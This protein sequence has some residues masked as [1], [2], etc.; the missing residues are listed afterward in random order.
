MNVDVK[1]RYFVFMLDRDNIDYFL[2]HHEMQLA[3][4]YI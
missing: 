2:K 1:D 3:L 4:R